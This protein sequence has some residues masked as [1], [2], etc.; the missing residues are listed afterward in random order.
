M[1]RKHAQM[2][3]WHSCSEAFRQSEIF[4]SVQEHIGADSLTATG[5][6]TNRNGRISVFTRHIYLMLTAN[7]IPVV[8]YPNKQHGMHHGK[9][10]PCM[11]FNPQMCLILLPTSMGKNDLHQN[12]NRVVEKM[13]SKHS[14]CRQ[15]QCQISGTQELTSQTNV[16][17]L[18]Y[19]Q[20]CVNEPFALCTQATHD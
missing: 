7:L 10:E 4:Y 13:H 12:A 18:V 1:P 16:I 17:W 15:W 19:D 2:G 14:H 3:K 6:L 8:I 11:S 9:P 5:F 20:E